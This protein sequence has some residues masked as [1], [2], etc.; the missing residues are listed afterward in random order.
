MLLGDKLP[1]SFCIIGH[2]PDRIL[3]Q[4]QVEFQTQPNQS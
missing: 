2:N 4:I 3:Q 1:S